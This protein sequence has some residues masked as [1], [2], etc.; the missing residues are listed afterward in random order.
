MKVIKQVLNRRYRQIWI[1]PFKAFFGI[2]SFQ[3][4]NYQIIRASTSIIMIL[5]EQGHCPKTIG[6]G[7][8]NQILLLSK[9]A[10]HALQMKV[11]RES[12]IN[13]WFRFMYSHKWNC[14]ASLFP[15]Q[16]YNVLSPT[17]GLSTFM[18][19]WAINIFPPSRTDIVNIFIAHRYM[20]VEIG[21][22]A[23]RFH[24]WEYMFRI[25]G[26]V[27]GSTIVPSLIQLETALWTQSY[28]M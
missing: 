10:W 23:T 3:A 6:I 9:L 28:I 11:R 19:L 12:N 13:V 8:A 15:K 18:Y 1:H 24:F 26:A 4:V 22:E 2:K 20:N 21:N 27:R 25:F 7:K 14:V 5:R 16:Y 17:F